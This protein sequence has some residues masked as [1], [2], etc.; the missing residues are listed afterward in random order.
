M[1]YYDSPPFPPNLRKDI[2]CICN[3]TE[4]GQVCREHTKS[5][6]GKILDKYFYSKL[7]SR[8]YSVKFDRLWVAEGS[9]FD[10]DLQI[11]DSSWS[12][13]ILIEGGKAARIDLDLL[14]F[15]AW[16]RKEHPPST[17]F[18]SLIAS[19]KELHRNITGTRGETAFDYLARLCNLFRATGSEV[20]NLLVVE[21][22]SGN[23][24]TKNPVEGNK[25]PKY[26]LRGRVVERWKKAECPLWNYL[27]TRDIC[28]EE[29]RRLNEEERNPAPKFRKFV[30]MED[31]SNI[32][33]WILGCH[34]P[35]LNPR[36]NP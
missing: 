15:I 9:K 32:R 29:D 11:T 10:L 21:F 2:E 1:T 28:L 23:S 3:S 18:V 34:F 5:P 24:Q 30:E 25:M 17:S 13:A 8:G 26:N 27:K 16:A 12:V 19:D 31:E 36:K 14:K 33:R 20:A 22:H 6:G 4:V 35:W 7:T